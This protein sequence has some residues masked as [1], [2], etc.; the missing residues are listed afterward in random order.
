MNAKAG[1][2]FDLLTLRNLT[3]DTVFARGEAYHRDGQVAILS[4]DKGRVLAQVA[5]TDD[6]R[7][8][9]TGR[10]KTIHGDC[11]CPAFE[12][13][14]FCKHL[15]ATASRG[16]LPRCPVGRTAAR[17]HRIDT[18]RVEFLPRAPDFQGKREATP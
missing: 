10:G 14:G 5:G 7:T 13:R 15:V 11:T 6:Y 12:D 18:N 17:A 1:P 9:I 3:G 2:R 4:L 16:Q 8:K